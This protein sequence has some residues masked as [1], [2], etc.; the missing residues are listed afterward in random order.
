MR[1]EQQRAAYNLAHE[2]AVMRQPQGQRQD[3]DNDREGVKN[4]AAVQVLRGFNPGGFLREFF[5][6]H[7]I[8]PAG[9]VERHRHQRVIDAQDREPAPVIV[10]REENGQRGQQ[11]NQEVPA[12]EPL[13]VGLRG[14]RVESFHRSFHR[15]RAQQG[16]QRLARQ[17]PQRNPQQR[18][19]RQPGRPVGG[20]HHQGDLHGARQRPLHGDERG[21]Q[22]RAAE[23]IGRQHAGALA[24]RADRQPA[25]ADV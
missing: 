2:N 8:L 18:Q 19:H 20:D 17:V 7:H 12:E 10:R 9:Q 25:L 6:E 5:P 4:R 1:E 22:G 13:C 15:A 24:Q 3:A 23:F 14:G 11:G 21:G 16:V